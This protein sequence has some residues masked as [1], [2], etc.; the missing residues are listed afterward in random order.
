MDD[1][2]ESD[3]TCFL[4][5]PIHLSSLLSGMPTMMSR[6]NPIDQNN[7]Q[8][9]HRLRSRDLSCSAEGDNH[10]DAAKRGSSS[11]CKSHPHSHSQGK[12]ISRGA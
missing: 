7:L 4:A 3:R 8:G 9:P 10:G 5:F 6:R 2:D 12:R 1:D 11:T